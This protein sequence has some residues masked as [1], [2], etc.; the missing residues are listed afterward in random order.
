MSHDNVIIHEKKSEGKTT[1]ERRSEK[2]V[3]DYQKLSTDF[4]EFLD[5]L[6]IYFPSNFVFQI[7][8]NHLSERG[9][10]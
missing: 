8:I 3:A 1:E 5:R 7:C 10:G 2:D 6:K 9:G 4:M